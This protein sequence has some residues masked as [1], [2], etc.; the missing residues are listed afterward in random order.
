[1]PIQLPPLLLAQFSRWL[2]FTAANG[3]GQV[4]DVVNRHVDPLPGMTTQYYAR[5]TNDRGETLDASLNVQD[6]GDPTNGSVEEADLTEL[7]KFL[8]VQEVLKMPWAAL[9]GAKPKP[10]LGYP[11][12]N[13]PAPPSPIGPSVAPGLYQDLGS[14]TQ[15]GQEYISPDG[16]YVA[17]RA[18]MFTIRWKLLS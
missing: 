10:P 12:E 2:E 7:Q 18:G 1:M 3:I 8:G 15:E 16:R 13:K 11:I 17:V 14:G 5:Y 4:P 9:H 6:F